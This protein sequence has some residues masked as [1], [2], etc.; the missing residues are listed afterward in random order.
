MPPHGR[1]IASID[2]FN[3]MNKTFVH[4]AIETSP[5]IFDEYIIIGSRDAENQESY[6]C[7][8]KQTVGDKTENLSV[9]EF[10]QAIIDERAFIIEAPCYPK[11]EKEKEGVIDRFWNKILLF[12]EEYQRSPARAMSWLLTGLYDVLNDIWD[13]LFDLFHCL[14]DPFSR[15]VR[16]AA[17]Y[18]FAAKNVALFM[19]AATTLVAKSAMPSCGA[20]CATKEIPVDYF[21]KTICR[22]AGKEMGGKCTTK[23]ILASKGCTDVARKAGKE[24]LKKSTMTNVCVTGI[25]EGAIALHDISNCKKMKDNGFITDEEYARIITK[26]VSG[27]LGATAGSVG[28]GM[29]G[30][31]LCP[32][33]VVGYVLGSVVGGYCGRVIGSELSG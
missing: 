14:K 19:Q 21:T 20:L 10:Y 28:A 4:L 30:Q 11:T 26:T 23:H 5:A 7:F 17:G 29:V 13:V 32:I 27:A 16:R 9:N 2:E 22:S 25:I 24:A 3:K 8:R 15:I 31:L 1:L 18:A 12:V 6:A 33:P